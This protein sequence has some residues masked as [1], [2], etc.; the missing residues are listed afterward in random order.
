M[1][2]QARRSG[3]PPASRARVRSWPFAQI[4]PEHF[5]LFFQKLLL[6][7]QLPHLALQARLTPLGLLGLFALLGSGPQDLRHPLLQLILPNTDLHRQHTLGVLNLVDRLL[8]L[9]GLQGHPGLELRTECSSFS[10]HGSLSFTTQR[11]RSPFVY[12]LALFRGTT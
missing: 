4:N 6:D 1:S 10:L 7:G 11:T 3:G 12:P 2:H 8:A 9:D 5:A